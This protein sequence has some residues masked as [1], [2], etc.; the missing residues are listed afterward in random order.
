MYHHGAH[1]VDW[2]PY[3]Q[4][5][6]LWMSEKTALDSNSAIRGGIPICWPWFGAGLNGVSSPIHGFARLTEWRLVKTSASDEVVT[7]TYI[8]IDAWRDKFDYAYR[9]TYEVSFGRE[10]SATLKV[11]NTGSVRFSFE[12]ALHTYL[13]VGDIHQVGITGLNEAEFLDRAPGHATGPHRQSGD[14][15]IVEETDRIYHST[16]DID[17]IDPS[18]TRRITVSRMGSQ[19]VIVWNPW[20]ERARSM[21]DIGDEEWMNMVCIETANVGEH[22]VSLSPGR[23][24]SIGFTLRLSS[25]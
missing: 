4:Q 11:R 14:I 1:V 24:H 15:T 6:V 7:A 2:T 3:L 23:E 25:L 5:P 19:D 10:F 13:R 12:E 9:V 16:E 8:L 18:L 20:I 22:A 17:V 21:P